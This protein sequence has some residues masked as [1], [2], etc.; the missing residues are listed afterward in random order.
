[1]HHAIK[2]HHLVTWCAPNSDILTT[3][4]FICV[5]RKLHCKS[6][7]VYNFNLIFYHLSHVDPTRPDPATLVNFLTRSEPTR[8][9]VNSRATLPGCKLASFYR[10]YLQFSPHDAMPAKHKVAVALCLSG[11]L[12]VCHK[13]AFCQKRLHLPL[14]SRNQHRTMASGHRCLKPKILM[15]FEWSHN[16]RLIPRSISKT[17]QHTDIVAV[18]G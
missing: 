3:L 9:S 13:P 1:M 2:S 18:K 6:S 16:F 7:A 17:V 5:C 8:G 4:Y 12:C 14:G 10:L 15:K 11:C